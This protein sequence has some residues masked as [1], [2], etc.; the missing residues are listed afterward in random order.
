MEIYKDLSSPA[1]QQ[2]EKLLNSQLSKNK[3]EEGKVIEGKI[4]KI[5]EKYIFLFVP[6]LK[7][8][9]VIDINEM[10]MIGMQ[11]KIAEGKIISVLLEKIE[12][13][14]GDVIVSAQ[15]AKKIKGWYELEKAYDDNESINGKIISKCKGGV[16]VEHVETESLMFC[17]GS[18]ISD[19]PMKNIDHLIGV[20]QKFAIIK[21]D[22]LRG[23]ACV[24]R[25]QIVSSSKKEDK[26]KI[27]AK[28]KVGD[29]IKDAVVKGYSSFGCFF[30]VNNEID[31]L[32]HLQEISYS[33]VNHP[34]EI[35]NIGE[36]HDLKVISIDKSK[37]QIGCSIKQLS[38]DPFEHISNY[39]QGKK[40]KVKV[41]K[42]ADY[43]CFCELEP[44]LSTLLHSSEI[45]WTK[46]NISAKKIFKVGDLVDC[47]ITEIDKEK[48]RVAIS[49]KLTI[50]NPYSSLEKKHPVGSKIEGIVTNTN[51]YAVYVKLGNYDIDGFLHANDLSY[52]DKPEEELKKYKKGI[53][54]IVK[55]LEINKDESKIRVGLKQLEKDPFDWFKDKKVNDTITI[56]VISSDNKG[57][58]V[59]PEGSDLQLLIKKSQIAV[60]SADARPSRFVGGERID[61]AIA[62]LNFNKR[63]A[64]LSIK[65]LE[66]LMNAKAIKEHSSPLSGKN[67]PFSSLS[68]QL[69]DKKK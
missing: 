14:N 63:K 43:G 54:L 18:Q 38:P 52:A 60:S 59:K 24:S 66:E 30:E 15:K 7:S 37:L 21:L 5:T 16:I 39:E 47:I 64:S 4:T 45:S 42:I 8:E 67:L 32:V 6:G 9:P 2:F 35:F 44:G 19:K 11:N 27:V 28:F 33:R 58:M 10:K 61:A 20:E 22:K 31:V 48:R 62:E 13:K 36:K 23:N 26:A 57:L 51:E 56:Q 3:I 50:E 68:D 29:I 69:D 1:S 49:H 55:I 41:V 34:D 53:K 65:L 25:R 46:K 12:D 17:P 40:Y